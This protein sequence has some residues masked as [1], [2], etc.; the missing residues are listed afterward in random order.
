MLALNTIE[1]LQESPD[2]PRL[3]TNGDYKQKAKYRSISQ[4]NYNP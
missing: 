4:S 3:L 1:Y 2:L